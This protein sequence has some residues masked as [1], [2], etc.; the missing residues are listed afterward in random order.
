[1]GKGSYATVISLCRQLIV[2]LPAAYLL[3]LTNQVDNV[4][5][6][7]PISEFVSLVITV[8]F[9]LRIYRKKIRPLEE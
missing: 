5:W 3:S 2:L 9:F 7:F 4:W 6:A 8:L 1:M